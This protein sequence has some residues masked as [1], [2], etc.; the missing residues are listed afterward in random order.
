M[1]T[2]LLNKHDAYPVTLLLD[3]LPLGTHYY[4]F[5]EFKRLN[6][7]RADTSTHNGVVQLD[8]AEDIFEG[9]IEQILDSDGRPRTLVVQNDVTGLK[10]IRL[11]HRKGLDV[12]G[13]VRIVSLE[14]GAMGRSCTPSLSG[15]YYDHG[16]ERSVCR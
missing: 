4:F 2:D 8:E 3:C 7:T 10:V 11:C 12:P 13:Q 1:L 16:T 15:F 6:D 5:E 9:Q 14:A